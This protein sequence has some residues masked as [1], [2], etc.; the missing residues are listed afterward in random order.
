[1]I[2]TPKALQT[3]QD[4]DRALAS[5]QEDLSQKAIVVK[6]FK[7]LIEGAYQYDFDRNLGETEEP[8]G[9]MPDYFV[10]EASEDTPRHQ[11]RRVENPSARIFQL[12]YT[13]SEVQAIIDQLEA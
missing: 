6:H 5:A 3:K 11:L 12:G 4:F 1:M 13:I 10:V 2:N 9:I 7:G 8:D